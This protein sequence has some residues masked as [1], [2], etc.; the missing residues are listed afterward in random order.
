MDADTVRAGLSK[1][2]MSLWDF[3]TLLSLEVTHNGVTKK[4]GVS[5]CSVSGPPHRVFFSTQIVVCESSMT[6]L[7]LKN[8]QKN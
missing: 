1:K 2:L 8:K 4:H 3:H 7:S 5:D 6:S